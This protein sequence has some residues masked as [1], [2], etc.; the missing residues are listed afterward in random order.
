MIPIINFGGVNIRLH[1]L[2]ASSR[3][4][5]GTLPAILNIV[6]C[7][8]GSWSSFAKRGSYALAFDG[9]GSLVRIGDTANYIDWS[10]MAARE[11]GGITISTWLNPADQV[12]SLH[13]PIMTAW[14]SR[15]TLRNLMF[16]YICD[17]GVTA[18]AYFYATTAAGNTYNAGNDIIAGFPMNNIIGSWH[19][20]V[21]VYDGQFNSL[22]VD[23]QRH[24]FVDRAS[25]GI[26][27]LQSSSYIG[28]SP[29][30]ESNEDIHYRGLIDEIAIYNIPL[31]SS[32]INLLYNDGQGAA[33][34]TVSSSNLIHYWN[35][36][37]NGPGSN[38][39]AA[40]SGTISGTLISM[41]TGT[42]C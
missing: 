11:N 42:V 12:P 33:A 13:Y 38:I 26:T 22:Y 9:T 41:L 39:L 35:M 32:G 37:S 23:G 30:F 10:G 34:T 24:A 7:N 16:S 31:S 6:P 2:R 19:H 15:A 8:S 36:E 14:D 40:T 18:S 4:A 20:V 29:K 17:H 21:F 25:D 5:S 27:S 1:L 28:F 3:F